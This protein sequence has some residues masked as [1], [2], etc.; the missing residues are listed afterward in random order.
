M[1]KSEAVLEKE[2][3]QQ[4]EGYGYERVKIKDEKELTQNLK[5]QL[6]K[7]NNTTF[8]EKEFSKILIHLNSGTIFE[9]AKKLR[10]KFLL[11]RDDDTP[12]YVEFFNMAEWCKNQYQVANQIT[13]KGKYKNRYDVTLLV[14]GIPLVQIELKKAGVEI[15]EAFNQIRRYHRHSYAGTLFDYV[16]IFVISNKANT[17]YFANNPD[18]SF[19]Q[20]FYWSDENNNKITN[21]FEFAESFLKPCFISKIIASYVVL[22]QAKKILMVLRPY[23]Y[24]AV[25]KIINRVKN[26]D[27]N[28][29]IWH[30]TGSGKTLTSF[31]ASQIISKMPDVKKVLFVVDRKDLDLQTVEEFNSYSKGSVDGTEN[32]RELVKQLKDEKRK[33]IV[34]TIQKL[35][36]AIKN[37]E[38]FE[39]LENEKVVIIFDECHRSQFGKT[40]ANIRR[41][42]KK[43]QLFGFTGTPIFKEN[44]VGGVTT[45]DV[46]DECLHKYVITD[47]ISDGN[48]LGF[49]VEY[50]GKYRKKDPDVIEEDIEVEEVSK[51]ILESDERIDKIVDYILSI[52]KQKTKNTF[53]AILATSS[54]NMAMKYYN[55]FKKK[56]H[57]LKVAT[58]FTFKANE[59]MSDML[60][61]DP[62]GEGKENKHI[63][64]QLEDAI[65]DYNEMFGTNYSTETFYDYYKNVQKRV[66]DLEIDIL[67]VVSMF[68]TGFDS[69]PLNTLY[70][71]KNLRFHGLIQAYSRTNRLLDARK[72]HGNIVCFRDLKKQTDEA[73]EL[74]GNKEAV[75]IV[76]KKPYSKQKKE[77]IKKLKELKKSIPQPS[78]VDNLKSEKE[79][80]EFVKKFRE[81]VRLKASLET[82]VE[83]DWKDIEI[84]EEEY[85][86]YVS[87]YLDIYNEVKNKEEKEE[88]KEKEEL[89]EIDF[90]LELIREDL[91]NYDYIINL[92]KRLK[93]YEK[94]PEK[95]EKQ[96]EEFLKKFDRD[97]RYRAKKEIVERFVEEKLPE[98]EDVEKFR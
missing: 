9:R 21:M 33:L 2:L 6:E 54:T 55:T 69:P 64:E 78:A 13:M 79:K 66:K 12:F 97:L 88:N 20:T 18:Q 85:F 28:G 1:A 5:R 58:V 37:K 57:D 84:D 41:A 22:A 39:H 25:E 29:Y 90:S 7:H 63:R 86:E 60:D 96:K 98:A 73:L 3:I 94:H 95:F 50:I 91:I 76:F 59:E 40:H 43:A 75:E 38:N 27:R 70:V 68:L 26:S 61:F 52:H 11:I 24:Y 34:T 16:Q 17:K 56:D 15:K 32:T 46:F 71:D 92:L 45:I 42:F 82:F 72:P 74:F 23:Q 19:E 10:D 89:E 49:S 65:R 8:S 31:K 14:N 87:K 35:D 47:A 36:R 67:I 80:V 30:T 62:M 4:L 48:V 83:F 77:F 81:L 53:N 44:N 51:E 93:E